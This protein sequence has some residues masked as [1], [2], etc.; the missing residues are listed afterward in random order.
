MRWMDVCIVE[1]FCF[2]QATGKTEWEKQPT[3]AG[4]LD[5]PVFLLAAKFAEHFFMVN[6]DWAITVDKWKTEE[7]GKY[8]LFITAARYIYVT[9]LLFQESRPQDEKGN[10][11][12]GGEGR[13]IPCETVVRETVK[14]GGKDIDIILYKIPEY[15]C[16]PPPYG[17]ATPTSD[18]DVGLVGPKSGE[19]LANFNGKFEGMFKK[20]SE[21]VFDTN[22]YAYT[23]EY[24]I[25]SKFIGMCYLLLMV[26]S[27]INYLYFLNLSVYFNVNICKTLGS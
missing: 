1:Y 21:E 25:P 22:I 3:L 16:Y 20:S 26:F 2:E 19:L 17:S 10:Y 13:L 5:D 11:Q 8:L 7:G 14:V 27:F 15:S 23:L 9:F 4:L 12:K 18:Y 24:V 6:S